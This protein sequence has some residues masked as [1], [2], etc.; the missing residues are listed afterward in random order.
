MPMPEVRKVWRAH[1]Q[2]EA[3]YFQTAAFFS[4]AVQVVGRPQIS[5]KETS[6]SMVLA[7]HK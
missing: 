5:S 3:N 4:Q 1:S 2:Q 7:L 6:I